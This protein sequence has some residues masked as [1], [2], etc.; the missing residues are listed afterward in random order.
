MLLGPEA[1]KTIGAFLAFGGTVGAVGC[2]SHLESRQ[3]RALE[4]SRIDPDWKKQITYL[5]K[6]SDNSEQ[7]KTLQCIGEERKFT[8]M[9]LTI[10]EE[11]PKNKALVSCSYVTS[12]PNAENTAKTVKL[13][14][15]DVT[16]TCTKQ[17]YEN[18]QLVYVCSVTSGKLTL[19]QSQENNGPIT[20][21]WSESQEPA[22]AGAA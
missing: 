19:E 5:I 2:I 7:G 1:L 4:A 11:E 16:C 21:T 15:K 18:S 13:G 6:T 10:G 12:K 8:D 20:L 17:P 9:S 3:K 22:S 14:E